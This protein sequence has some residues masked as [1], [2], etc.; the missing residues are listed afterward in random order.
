MIGVFVVLIFMC[1]GVFAVSGVSPASYEVDFEPGYSGEFVFN[2]VIEKGAEDLYA[3]GDL[4]EYVSFDKRSVSGREE[5]VVSLNLPSEI[6]S[7]GVNYIKII[8]GNAMGGIKVRVPY[9]ERY[10]EVGLNAPNANVGEV[11]LFELELSGKGNESVIVS[12]RIEI[13]R[14]G[15]GID[16]IGVEDVEVFPGDEVSVNVSIDTSDYLAGDYIAVGFLDYDDVSVSVDNPFRL[17]EFSVELVDYSKSFRENKID[18]FEIL[19]ESLWDDDM[20]GV[21]AEVNVLG[22]DSASFVSSSEDLDAWGRQVLVGFLDSSEIE[23][24]SFEAEIILHY[25]NESVSGVVELKVVEGFD[26]VFWVL[27]LV[28]VGVLGFLFWR[29]CIFIDRFKKHR[30]KK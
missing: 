3:E 16:V 23:G 12:P 26:Y 20:R 6:D 30:I 2:F 14:D 27:I 11:V 29:C 5:V 15:E 24:N 4:A 25:G 21:Y 19:V 1:S 10:V 28:V 17:G 7:P 9:P 18:R 13:Y 8:A 22:F